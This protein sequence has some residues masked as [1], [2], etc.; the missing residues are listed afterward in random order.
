M[1]MDCRYSIQAVV[2][3]LP[4]QNLWFEIQVGLLMA[5][6][7]LKE[8]ISIWNIFCRKYLIAIAEIYLQEEKS[9]FVLYLTVSFYN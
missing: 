4:S 6:G 7:Q 9:H 1:V 3:A 8:H 5:Y 2:Y